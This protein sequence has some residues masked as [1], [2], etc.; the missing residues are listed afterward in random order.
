LQKIIMK[1]A[2]AQQAAHMIFSSREGAD[3]FVHM[4]QRKVVDFSELNLR[5]L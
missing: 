2:G 1:Q 3:K 5:V 4:N